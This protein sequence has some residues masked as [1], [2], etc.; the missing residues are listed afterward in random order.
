MLKNLSK[1]GAYLLIFLIF[2]KI[3]LNVS[4]HPNY[5]LI[6]YQYSKLLRGFKITLIISIITL[7]IS[8]I[9]GFIFYILMENKNIFLNTFIN[10]VKE[11]ILGTPL[12]VMIFLVVYVFGV[13]IKITNKLILGI[14]ALSFYMTPY[15][16]NSY[17]AGSAVISK[18]QKIIME[19]YNFNFYTK[20][21]YIIIPQMIKPLIPLLINNFSSIIKGSALLKIISVTEISYMITVISNKNYAAIEGY[22]IMW[23]MY[24]SITIPLSLLANKIGRRYEFEN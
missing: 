9:S 22:I 18:E 10:I 12:I 7:F 1:L 20:Y 24:L 3:I 4:D 2:F 21:K 17:K 14:A 5:N 19:L 11:I 8:L 16:A 6:L 15:I 13:R 23:I